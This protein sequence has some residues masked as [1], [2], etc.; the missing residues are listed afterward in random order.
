[1]KRV[2]VGMSGGVD[3]SVAAAL[4]K[5]AGYDVTGVFIKIEILNCDWRAERRDAMRVAAKL[6]IPLIT[7][8]LSREYKKRVVNYMIREYRAG[9]TPNPDVECNRVI[10][11]GMFYDW[12]RKNGAD[13]VATGHYMGGEKD[14]SYFL[15]TLKR[16]QLKHC[17][18]PID[19]HKKSDVRKLAKKFGLPNAEKKDSQG[20]CFIGQIDVKV[21]LQEY[22]K[23]KRGKVVDE[24]GQTIGTHQGVWF[25]TI[26]EKHI[27]YVVRKNTKKNILCVADKP[28]THTSKVKIERPNW[29]VAPKLNT[30]Y[31]AR[32]RYRG[33]L[34]SCHLRSQNLV[35]FERPP[36]GVAPGQSLVLYDGDL[37]VGGGVIA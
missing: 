20:L 13:F 9:R 17:L 12:A 22:I 1:M 34:Y 36:E 2:F 3:S 28:R 21:F 7:I 18:F 33:E 6:E 10:K 23:P 31:Q 4:L 5:H 32:V 27:K 25:Y 35:V 19:D 8:D 14:Q 16:E 24:N 15:W 30:T 26:G 37:L 29:Q 11:F